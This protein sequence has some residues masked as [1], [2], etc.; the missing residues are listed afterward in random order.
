MQGVVSQASLAAL[1]GVDQS[2]I[3]NI[4]R[5]KRWEWLS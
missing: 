2:T 4:Q 5:A 3:S 1:Y